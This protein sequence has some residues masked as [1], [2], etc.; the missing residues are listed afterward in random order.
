M[1][2]GYISLNINTIA[3]ALFRTRGC[4]R[5]SPEVF[6]GKGV[7]KICRKFTGEHP[8]QSAISIKLQSK[9]F[10]ITLQQGNSSVN[11]LYIFRTPFYRTPLDDCFCYGH[12]FW[13]KSLEFLGLSV[14][15][16]KFRGKQSFTPGNFVKP[17]PMEI[18]HDFLLIF[19]RNSTSF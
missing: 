11:V 9:F 7:L 10:Q 19:H 5:S 8:C 2:P 3:I 15:P 16:W 1:D 4:G 13:K 12:S 17:R 14:Y 6:L 18:P